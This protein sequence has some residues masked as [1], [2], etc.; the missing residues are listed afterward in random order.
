MKMKVWIVCDWCRVFYKLFTSEFCWCVHIYP[1]KSDQNA[2]LKWFFLLSWSKV[3]FFSVNSSFKS[4]K[5]WQS[6][7]FIIKKLFLLLKKGVF[8][9]FKRALT[10]EMLNMKFQL[11]LLFHP[12][13]NCLINI[14]TFTTLS[15]ISTKVLFYLLNW[16]INY[17]PAYFLRQVYYSSFEKPSVLIHISCKVF[18]TNFENGS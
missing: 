5:T 3:S 7:L 14:D 16:E 1:H 6:F 2:I 17:F 11:K 13:T 8:E 18:P 15:W 9:F 12:L 4:T 10:S